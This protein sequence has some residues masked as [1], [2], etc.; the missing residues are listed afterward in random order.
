M[1]TNLLAHGQAPRSAPRSILKKHDNVTA[2]ATEHKKK[3]P[4]K[5]FT[6]NEPSLLENLSDELDELKLRPRRIET[7]IEQQQQQ[8][9][10]KPSNRFKHSALKQNSTAPAY[11][12]LKKSLRLRRRPRAPLPSVYILHG[13]EIKRELIKVLVHATEEF[14]DAFRNECVSKTEAA[15][16]DSNHIFFTTQNKDLFVT[17][18]KNFLMDTDYAN[19]NENDTSGSLG[20]EATLSEPTFAELKTIRKQCRSERLTRTTTAQLNKID[21][22][23]FFSTSID[24]SGN[25]KSE[26]FYGTSLP[27]TSFIANQAT[28]AENGHRYKT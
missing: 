12:L 18:L 23:D 6:G 20:L 25:V 21:V 17:M 5:F 13:D 22:K 10:A 11:F 27:A 15:D 26:G 1:N 3:Q 14:L 7:P 16:N 28:A 9:N 8:Q 4:P 19:N 24:E 2:A